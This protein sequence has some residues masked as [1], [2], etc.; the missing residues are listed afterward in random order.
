MKLGLAPP[1]FFHVFLFFSFS[2]SSLASQSSMLPSALWA[3][4][5]VLE[6]MGHAMKVTST[7]KVSV[8]NWAVPTASSCQAHHS[9]VSLIFKTWR[10]VLECR[11]L[12]GGTEMAQHAYCCAASWMKGRR[13]CVIAPLACEYDLGRESDLSREDDECVETGRRSWDGRKLRQCSRR[14]PGLISLVKRRI[15][16]IHFLIKERKSTPSM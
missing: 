3:E 11:C 15:D 10:T 2:F 14:F 8:C 16:Q 12:R 1:A 5:Y 6:K 4:T 9:T 7:F 13:L